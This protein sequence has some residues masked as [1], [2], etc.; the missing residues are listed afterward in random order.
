M[1]EGSI[2]LSASNR[3]KLNTANGNTASENRVVF[4]VLGNFGARGKQ[5]HGRELCAD[6][7]YGFLR[8]LNL[9]LQCYRLRNFSVARLSASKFSELAGWGCELCFCAFFFCETREVGWLPCGASG[10]QC[11]LWA[12]C[13]STRRILGARFFQKWS[14]WGVSLR[15]LCTYR[16]SEPRNLLPPGSCGTSRASANRIVSCR[17][18]LRFLS[19]PHVAAPTVGGFRFF[20]VGVFPPMLSQM[21]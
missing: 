17:G 14:L 15:K 4:F 21:P 19:V 18:P 9:H 6:F 13:A 20:R 5:E 12:H 10:W 1:V 11:L 7:F 3:A 2:K 8:A 16:V